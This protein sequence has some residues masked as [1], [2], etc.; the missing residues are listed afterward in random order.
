MFTLVRGIR[1]WLPHGMFLA[2]VLL[3]PP[4]AGANEGNSPLGQAVDV[5]ADSLIARPLGLAASVLGSGL[6][7]FTYPFVA[8]GAEEGETKVAV[9]KMI[10]EPVSFTFARPLGEGN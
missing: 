3:F 2:T 6:F 7:V 10:M 4:S 5:V 8:L 1:G 9:D